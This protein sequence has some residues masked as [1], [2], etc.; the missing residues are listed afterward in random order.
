MMPQW[1]RLVI[2]SAGVGAGFALVSGLVAG[3]VV[4]YR[5]RLRRQEPRSTPAQQQPAQKNAPTLGFNRMKDVSP[6]IDEDAYFDE[7]KMEKRLPGN[8]FVKVKRALHEAG[9]MQDF[10]EGFRNSKECSGVTFY[11][12]STKVPDFAVQIT[13]NFHDRP[14]HEQ[15]WVWMLSNTRKKELGGLGTQ[16]SAKLTAR[17]VCLT[18]W[19]DV[20]PNHFKKPGGKIE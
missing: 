16:S 14:N 12:N 9:L 20:D 2:V 4:W 3:G 17:D 11:M 6:I 1:K 15:E 8:E 13:V 10:L 18:V 7:I 19:E 5:S